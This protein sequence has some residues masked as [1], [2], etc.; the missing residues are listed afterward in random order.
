MR[1][2]LTLVI[3]TILV[4]LTMSSRLSGREATSVPKS[5]QDSWITFLSHRTGRNVLYKMRPDGSQLTPI[6]GGEIRDVPMVVEGVKLYREP[7]WTRQSPNAKYFASWVY[8]RGTPDEKYQGAPPRAMLYVG[9]LDGRWSRIEDPDCEEEFAWSPDSK[10]IAF[11]IVS[12]RGKGYFGSNLI[13]TEIVI[14]GFDGSNVEYVLERPGLWTIKDW[15]PDGKR[16]LL[17]KKMH[18]ERPVDVNDLVEFDLAAAIVA[19]AKSPNA[20]SYRGN[21]WSATARG[22]S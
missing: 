22:N 4:S 12:G 16:L 6:F 3:A 10:R 14:A 18:R 19:R 21:E 8:D 7:H 20:T 17:A 1:T 13:S 5:A 9:G 15:S 11:R 2:R